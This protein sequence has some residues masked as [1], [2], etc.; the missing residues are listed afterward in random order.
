MGVISAG[1]FL[2]LQLGERCR[3]RTEHQIEIRVA[4][5]EVDSMG[6]LYHGHYFTYFEKARLELLRA[7]GQI[8]RDMEEAGIYVVVTHCECRFLAAARYDDLLTVR[9][10]VKSV[11][12][13]R[14]EHEYEVLNQELLLARGHATLAMVDREGKVHRLPS[15]WRLEGTT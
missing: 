4:Y 2:Y 1:F 15:S 12:G 10:R 14:I 8:Y 6:R 9:V 7:S 5:H 13:A 11:R 3:M